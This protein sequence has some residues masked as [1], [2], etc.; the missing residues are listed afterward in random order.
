MIAINWPEII[1]AHLAKPAWAEKG[2]TETE[3][4]FVINAIDK[5]IGTDWR[6]EDN[7][8]ERLFS[9]SNRN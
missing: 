8:N 6:K 5:T 1:K 4:P 7:D 3:I 2:V 9:N